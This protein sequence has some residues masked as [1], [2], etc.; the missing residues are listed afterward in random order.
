MPPTTY[1][2]AGSTHCVPMRDNS[3]GKYGFKDQLSRGCFARKKAPLT[4]SGCSM[5]WRT[6]RRKSRMPSRRRQKQ[7]NP[8][9]ASILR[10]KTASHPPFP[11]QS[12]GSHTHPPH[13]LLARPAAPIFGLGEG[14]GVDGD[15]RLEADRRQGAH[16]TRRA[17]ADIRDVSLWPQSRPPSALP[18][19]RKWKGEDGA[20]NLN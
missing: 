20:R 14:L 2:M 8:G 17:T 19:W 3:S 12:N 18:I 10:K 7:K 16:A 15:L 4:G 6:W 1:R 11:R 9:Q 13:V 5:N